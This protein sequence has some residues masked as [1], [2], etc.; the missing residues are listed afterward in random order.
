VKLLTID[1]STLVLGVGLLDG[2]R[3]LGEVTTNLHKNHSVR[4]MPAIVQL[5]ENL[6]LDAQEL[7]GV[8]VASGP[9]SYTGIR[10]GFTTAKTIAWSRSIPL[11]TVSSLA[12]LAMNGLRFPGG[13]VPLF[14]ARRNRVYTGLYRR[15]G[16]EVTCAVEEQVI[17]IDQW[18]EQLEDQGPLLFLGEDAFRF[19][20]Q[21][22]QVLGDE[23]QF[24]TGRENLVSA[25]H[26]GQ[27]AVTRLEAGH[28]EGPEATPEYLQ[29]TEAE[30]KWV[31]QQRR[32]QG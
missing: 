15:I 20:E 11:V 5:M 19:Q 18:L 13:I 8:A 23:A 9:G 17:D 14:D 3:V 25:A 28:V 6:G 1:T 4:L 7:D 24:G 16:D 21:I 30:A 31:S 26:L 2:R 32:G 12:A 29:M 27:L 10:I 22:Q